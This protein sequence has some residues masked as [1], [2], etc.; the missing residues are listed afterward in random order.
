ML[1]KIQYFRYQRHCYIYLGENSQQHSLTPNIIAN[2]ST[3]NA[4]SIFFSAKTPSDV[5]FQEPDLDNT[6]V[7]QTETSSN[8]PT[9]YEIESPNRHELGKRA[10]ESLSIQGEYMKK[11][12]R[13]K[14][15][16]AEHEVGTIVQ[17]S[18]K[19]IDTDRTESNNA[20]LVVVGKISGKH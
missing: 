9:Y 4:C 6:D 1:W 16:I 7:I 3:S 2:E 15:R 11:C 18:V 14:D 13:K 10:A 12:A 17:V 8:L 5:E 20:T 19:D